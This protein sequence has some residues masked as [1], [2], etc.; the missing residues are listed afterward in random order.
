MGVILKHTLR[1]IFAK[2]L[3]TL[4]LVVSITICSFAGMM[5]FDMSNSLDN[6]FIGLFSQMT[7]TAN[8]LI[9]S[10]DDIDESDF[11]GI[12][13]F[14]AA[15]VSS[16][17]S[18]ITLRNDQMYAYYNQKTLNISGVDTEIA[19][20]MRII[21]K[22]IVLNADEIIISEV[23]AKELELKE[24]DTLKVYGD[25]YIDAGFTVKKIAKP[26]GLLTGEYSAVVS[27]EGMGK[28]CYN[29]HPKH[30]TV[31]IRVEDK[32][33]V[34]EFCNEIEERFP[35]YDVMD[36]MGG[37]QTQDQI[38]MLSNVFKILFLITLMLVIFVTVTL[39]ERIMRDRMSTIGTLRSLGVSPNVTARIILIENMFYGLFGGIIGTGL[40]KASR[41]FIYNA[42]FTVNAGN[43]EV[44]MDL[45][46]VSVP[47]MIAVIIGAIIVE[48]LC[49]LRE[50]LKSTNTAIRDIIFDNKDTEYKFKK[51]NKVMAVIC[52]ILAGVMAVLMFTICKDNAV[53]GI[54]GFIFTVLSLFC[55]YPF[56]L[57]RV[58]ELIE[59]IG[60]NG[61]NPVLGL[62]A[63]NLRTN[64]T[65]I[66]S[67]KLT[68]IATSLCL[69]LFILITSEKH[70]VYTP[71][72]DA[73]VILR[74][75]S[76]SPVSYEYI[77]TLDGVDKVEYDY[78]RNDK[79]LV[80]K[81]KINDYLENKY[82]KKFDDEFVNISVFGTEGN[83]EL[84]HG[85]K[86]LPDKINEG[87]IYIA[88]NIARQQ[89]LK[90]GDNVDLLLNAEGV[91][92]YQGTFK[93]AGIID[94]GMADH[95]NKTIVL[96]LDLYKQV[97]YDRPQ[98]AF[99]KTNDPE[100]TV[101]LIKSYSS[102][103]IGKIN[104]MDEYMEE[105]KN[106]A[107]GELALLYMIIII[108][109]SLS[110][111]GIYSNQIVGFESRKRES[112]VLVSTAMSKGK[113]IK[114]FFGETMLSGI[115]AI[116][117][118]TVI[119]LVETV[120]LFKALNA[121]REMKLFISVGQTVTFLLTIFFTFSITVI[122]TMKDINKMK[123]AEQLKYE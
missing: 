44:E 47:V 120:F 55:G 56:L 103:T 78:S 37:K 82:D 45:G 66:G 71:A 97:Y 17:T 61:N 88:K 18:N 114:L 54:L 7:G 15:Y 116:G 107:G 76:E 113:L 109:A 42:V 98:N 89:K 25:N 95:S 92:P 41:D 51:K 22:D 53:V 34:S 96:P 75:L 19:S 16:K 100:K 32:S 83:P 35:N 52:A 123:I 74:D 27:D 1:N 40:Y 36:L 46:N 106:I 115:I 39:S 79:I 64:K 105:M 6:I 20:K 2:P 49:P 101:E 8:V 13:G 112:A 30:E 4:F 80:G 121:L 59:K 24:G 60:M 104:T 29:G 73:E 108:G 12:S 69:V 93:V 122:K 81:E 11:E 33:K 119:G 23:M 26:N 87:E 50:L 70:E 62:A 67:S 110:L 14:E 84:N 85:Y 9:S 65:S 48:M 28:L 38:K 94:S 68:F 86:G 63:T 117:L 99:I 31:Y 10:S 91:I 90:A 118:G 43:L 21:P 5:A 3:M 77:E 111:I 57:R 72:A 58:S 102:S